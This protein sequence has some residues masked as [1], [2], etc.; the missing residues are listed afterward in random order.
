MACLLDSSLVGLR[1]ERAPILS[2]L[3]HHLRV[4]WQLRQQTCPPYEPWRNQKRRSQKC[5]ELRVMF[6]NVATLTYGRKRKDVVILMSEWS[7]LNSI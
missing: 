5:M 2:P 4:P 7:T 3:N 1:T 6:H